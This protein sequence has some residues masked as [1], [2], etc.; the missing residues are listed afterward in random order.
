LTLLGEKCLGF[1]TIAMDVNTYHSLY[2]TVIACYEGTL[3]DDLG[4]SWR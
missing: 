2:R 4:D 3:A 1:Y